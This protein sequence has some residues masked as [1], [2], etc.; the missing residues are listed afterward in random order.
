MASAGWQSLA[1]DKMHGSVPNVACGRLGEA[2]AFVGGG[3]DPV[4]IVEA[5]AKLFVFS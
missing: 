2:S 4:G 5:G 3:L 1:A